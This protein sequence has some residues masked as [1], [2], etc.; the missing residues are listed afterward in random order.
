MPSQLYP[1]DGA[2]N[3]VILAPI[4]DPQIRPSLDL[5]SEALQGIGVTERDSWSHLAITW[6]SCPPGQPAARLDY[7]CEVPPGHY[8]RVILCLSLPATVSASFSL[9]LNGQW[10]PSGKEASGTGRRMEV[11]L[12]LPQGKSLTGI[13]TT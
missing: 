6:S 13:R 10:R 4:H 5:R 7:F 11:D 1:L 9:Q 12:R 3:E 2:A 8:D